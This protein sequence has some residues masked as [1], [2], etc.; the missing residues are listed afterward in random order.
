MAS[1]F[2]EP[3][4]DADEEFFNKL[5][6]QASQDP[7]L[8]SGMAPPR[9]AVPTVQVLPK[10]G[11]CVK[12]KNSKQEKVFVN[13]CQS[14]NVPNA[15]DLTDDELLKVLDSEDPYSFRIPM[16]IGEPHVEMDKSG[17][18]CTAY[19]VVINPNFFSKIQ[20]NELFKTFFLTVTLE[21]IESKYN[22]ELSRE[23]IILKNR[24]FVGHLL[25]Q[26]VR[27]QSKPLIMESDEGNKDILPSSEAQRRPPLIQEMDFKEDMKSKGKQPDFRILQEPPEGHPEFLVAE[28]NLPQL[29]V[30]SSLTVD[31]GEDRILLQTR[32]NAY[33]L[34]IYIPYNVIQEECGAQ[35]NRKTRVLTVTMPV[36]P[37]S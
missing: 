27:T 17:G 1:I 7:S 16:A 20:K 2:L 35:F 25:E 13:V 5:L 8:L 19:D 31:I 14:E 9:G 34:D 23:W 33:Y 37:D 30:A 3:E 10:P 36:Q 32:S 11:F 12:T 29:K 6:L 21:G 22:V 4:Q 26:N 24:K 28:I 15:K 18:G